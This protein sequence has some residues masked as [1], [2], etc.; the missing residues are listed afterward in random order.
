MPDGVLYYENFNVENITT[1]VDVSKYHD[2]LVQ[3]KYDTKEVDFLIDGFK[4][5]FSIVYKGQRNVRMT[6]PN[7][8]F[9]Q[10][11]SEKELWNKVMKE[12]KLKRFAG[13][14]TE[15]PFSTYIQSP[16][17][18]V[19]KDGGKETRL[20]FHLS[21]PKGRGTSVNANTPQEM[22]KVKYPAFDKAIQLCMEAGVNC[23][24]S[25][26]DMKSAFRNLGILRK[27]W[28]Y[29]V[30]MAKSPIDGKRYYFFDKC[31]PFGS[32]VSCS[33]FQRFSNSVAHIVKALTGFE[34]VNYLD[35]Y[36][37]MALLLLLCNQQTR[38]F[39]KVCEWIKFPVSLEKTF[40]GTNCLVFLG[41]LINTVT[42]TVSIPVD[43]LYKGID[44]ITLVL[45][46]KNKKLTVK[47][48]QSI[49]G[50]LNFLGKMV[51]PGRAFTRRLY[52]YT[53]S[54]KTKKLKQHHHIRINSEMRKDL[55]TWLIFLRNPAAFSRPFI[56]FCNEIKSTQI[57]WYT[58]AS[59]K[60]GF[61]GV[62]NNT[63]WMHEKWSS[64]FLEKCNPSIQYQ[65]LYALVA[66]ILKWIHMFSNSRVT[67]FCDNLAVCRMINKTSSSCRNCMVLLRIF[68]MKCMVENAR[69]FAEHVKSS[70]NKLADLLSRDD[71]K[72]FLRIT[73]YKYKKEPDT[74]PEQIWPP[75]KI[76][77]SL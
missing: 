65:E 4:N 25:K 9:H 42:Q 27:H 77:L 69:V 63:F 21:Y 53:A 41:M 54:D 44:M 23:N 56:D 38:T 20:I 7:L 47:Q 3:T 37:F 73:K 75:E 62:C 67:I 18:L 61:G 2:L 66:A 28:R 52:A 34:N 22:C 12:V 6:S 17:G 1:P 39:L 72:E 46:N 8:R 57:N 15:I 45:S 29:L 40:W 14:F 60:I 50:F 35:D 70:D 33:H 59:G 19:P 76:W 58:D 55:E 10:I 43:K 31:L 30:M 48:L 64:D 24:I 49:C 74:V 5:G 68:V 71:I 11:G 13:P 36:L 51:V 26:S 16:L 32:S